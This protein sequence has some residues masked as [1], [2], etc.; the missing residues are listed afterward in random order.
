MEQKRP[1]S[2]GQVPLPSSP[3]SRL[4]LRLFRHYSLGQSHVRSFDHFVD[5]LV[6]YIVAAKKKNSHGQFSRESRDSTRDGT[7]LITIEKPKMTPLGSRLTGT[8]YLSTIKVLADNNHVMSFD[9]PVPLFSK[10]CHLNGKNPE[11][12][13][14]MGESPTELP[15][16]LIVQAAADNISN[17]AHIHKITR[18]QTQPHTDIISA[19]IRANMGIK[20]SKTEI[21]YCTTCSHYDRDGCNTTTYVYMKDNTLYMCLSLPK[22]IEYSGHKCKGLKVPPLKAPLLAFLDLLYRIEKSG[23]AVIDDISD[24]VDLCDTPRIEEL[25]EIIMNLTHKSRRLALKELMAQSIEE[26]A[27]KLVS[28]EGE[29]LSMVGLIDIIK[30]DNATTEASMYSRMADLATKCVASTSVIKEKLL[31]VAYMAQ[32][33]LNAM[34]LRKPD[35]P[36]N[37]ANKSVLTMGAFFMNCARESLLAALRTKDLKWNRYAITASYKI[38]RI[39]ADASPKVPRKPVLNKSWYD[40]N[41]LLQELAPLAGSRLGMPARMINSSS[42]GQVCPAQ[43]PESDKVGMSL[44]FA[45]LAHISRGSNPK[46]I[47]RI[48]RNQSG[49]SSEPGSTLLLMNGV[50]IGWIDETSFY[51]AKKIAKCDLETYDVSFVVRETNFEIYTTPGNIGT[52]CF[53]VSAGALVIDEKNLWEASHN[54]LVKM[55]AMEMVCAKELKGVAICESIGSFYEATPEE[56]SRYSYCYYGLPQLLGVSAGSLPNSNLC[57]QVRTMY[58]AVMNCSA[59]DTTPVSFCLSPMKRL[60]FGDRLI[61][62]TTVQDEIEK[63]GVIQSVN[64]WVAFLMHP[65]GYEDACVL[66]EET[67]NRMAYTRQITVVSETESKALDHTTN[68]KEDVLEFRGIAVDVIRDMKPFR[69]IDGATGLPILQTYME[70]GDVIIAKYRKDPLTG[71][72]TDVSIR[73]GIDDVGRVIDIKTRNVPANNMQLDSKSRIFVTLLDT[74]TYGVGDKIII[75]P[76]QKQV[77]AAVLPQHDMPIVAEGDDAG[78]CIGLVCSNHILPSRMTP[79]TLVE[80]ICNERCLKEGIRCCADDG[81]TI[82]F[83]QASQESETS[84][85]VPLDGCMKMISWNGVKSM[86]FVGLLHVSLTVHNAK[87]KKQNNDGDPTVIHDN[88]MRAPSGGRTRESA[89]RIGPMDYNAAV[90]GAPAR[91]LEATCTNSDEIVR[92]ICVD[93]G[94]PTHLPTCP[95]CNRETVPTTLT[96]GSVVLRQSLQSS[97]IELKMF[98]KKA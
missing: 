41:S 92:P 87:D 43:T 18:D 58:A 74:R 9:M 23:F 57:Y 55:G 20:K 93:C 7:P 31:T 29:R 60:S 34:I 88:V 14:A 81:R 19:T 65:L 51:A 12:L 27:L 24:S 32:M 69:N 33:Q 97:G 62:A 35:D 90:V 89:L 8:P 16:C 83:G 40:T 94:T 68:K 28:D 4:F 73:A 85:K 44:H 50:V 61:T 17:C 53:V 22:Q 2:F 77:C 75:V 67:A 25:L 26:Y 72:L 59:L 54:K 46:K 82:E 76:S 71:L 49:Y 96:Y 38:N 47:V 48:L 52:I 36:D 13:L 45:N 95:T 70:I 56:R 86:A 3:A 21:N 66:S 79:G 78:L 64:L 37:W 11:Q 84:F 6:D 91:V 30:G 5:N 1:T 10:L 42:Y 98:P 39:E 80:A 63:M 15:G